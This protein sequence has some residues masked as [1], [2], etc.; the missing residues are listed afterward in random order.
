MAVQNTVLYC[1]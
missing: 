1:R